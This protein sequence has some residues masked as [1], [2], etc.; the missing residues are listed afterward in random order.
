VDITISPDGRWL[1]AAGQGPHIQIWDTSDWTH[2]VRLAA[3]NVPSIAFDPV[4]PRLATVSRSGVAAIWDIAE[5]RRVVTLQDAGEPMDHVAYSPDGAWIANASRDG[6]VRV[7]D[8]ASGKLAAMLRDH[9]GKIL[10]VEFDSTSTWIASGGADGVVTVSDRVTGAR[11]ATFEG[12]HGEAKMV[13]FAPHAKELVAASVDGIARVW[14]VH[15]SYRHFSSPPL[16]HGCG[17]DVVPREDGR[18]LAVSCE[19]GAQVWD[20]ANDQ[21]LAQLP[22]P[23]PLPPIPDPYP[24]VTAL[25]DRAAVALGNAVTVYALPGGALVQTIEHPT[26]VRT[27]AFAPTGHDLVTASADG[28]LFVVREG[29]APVALPVPGGTGGAVTAVAFTPDGQAIAATATDHRIR[30]Y[31]LARG[32]VVY[33]LDGALDPA[34]VRALRVSPDGQRLVAMVMN[35][36]TVVPVLWDLPNRRRI[37]ALSAGKEVVLAARFVDDRRIITTSRDGIARLWNARTGELLRAF[38]GSSVVLFDAAVDPGGTV[39]ATAAGDGAIRFWD[40][41][42]ARLIWVLHAHRSFVNGLH[43]AGPDLISRGYDG[44]IARWSLPSA[45]PPSFAALVSCLPRRLDEKTGAL[46]DNKLCASAAR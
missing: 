33:E 7:W 36:T 6:I 22:G 14:P 16:G 19:T 3:P 9:H 2:V 30:V 43:F 20:T 32:Q 27:L 21:L 29:Q 24:A 18:F 26:L 41:A 4:R 42:S 1:A 10:W 38:V 23:Q 25:G 13:R 12:A 35:T 37:A 28:T 17:T 34:E 31:D 8:A 39:L 44:D 40:L 5:G 46:V 15:S 45:P 11:V